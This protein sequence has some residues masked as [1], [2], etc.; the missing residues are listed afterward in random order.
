MEDAKGFGN[1]AIALLDRPEFDPFV[2]IFSDLASIA[3][4]EGN[5]EQAVALIRKG[6]EHPADRTDRFCLAAL[7]FILSAAGQQDE[8]MSTGRQRDSRR[9]RDRRT[10]FDQPRLFWQ[11]PR[12]WRLSDPTAALKACEHALAVATSSGNRFWANMASSR[13]AALHVRIGDPV[14]ALRGYRQIF[15]MQAAVQ[16]ILASH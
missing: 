7:P 8:A 1:E 9:R 13:I 10:E 3:L 12:R 15:H 2:W 16:P 5:L 6:A 11:S 14:V 4:F